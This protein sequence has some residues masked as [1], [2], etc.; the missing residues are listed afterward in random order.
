MRDRW[1]DLARHIAAHCGDKICASACETC[2][3]FTQ[4]LIRLYTMLQ[5]EGSLHLASMFWCIQQLSACNSFFFLIVAKLSTTKAQ[6]TAENWTEPNSSVEFSS[7][8]RCALGF[9]DW[10]LNRLN[11]KQ[12]Y[13]TWACVRSIGWYFLAACG[14]WQLGRFS[15][16]KHGCL[17][18]AQQ[19]S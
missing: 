19:H 6:C 7:V 9:I 2:F 12:H 10:S 8:F 16:G 4:V 15:V 18:P 11:S 3:R 1:D 5:V 14:I 17:R 13:S